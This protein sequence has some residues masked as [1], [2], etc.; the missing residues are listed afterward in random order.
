MPDNK[1]LHSR[2]EDTIIGKGQKFLSSS[3]AVTIST[4]L[5]C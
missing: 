2:L 4:G 5:D 3:R 1:K